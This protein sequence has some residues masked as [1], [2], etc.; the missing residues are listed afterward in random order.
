VRAFDLFTMAVA[1][2]V[3]VQ[4]AVIAALLVQRA[5][6]ARAARALRDDITQRKESEDALRDSQQRLTMA[7]AAGAVG[8]WDWNFATSELFID[9]G[10]KSLLGFG[11]A[12]ISTR[13]DDWGSR[14][15][16]D[17]AP[18]AAAQI[19]ACVDGH[20]DVYEIE[21]RM[22]HKDGSVR[23]FL[24]R[25]SA[26]R[27]A[28]GSLQR[29]VGTKVDITERKI[30]AEQFRLAIEAAPAGMLM[31]DRTDAIVLVNAQIE[32][33]FGY[34]R[35][36]LVTRSVDLLIPGLLGAGRELHG[37]RRDGARI[38]VEIRLNPID[39]RDGELVLV[40]VVDIAERQRA[41]REN[42]D[43]MQQLQHLAGSLITA[44]DAERARIARD[45][46]DDVS[47][48]LAGLSIALSG[49]KRR[50]A[51]LS[52]DQ[53]ASAAVS[54]IQQRAVSLAE[55]VRAL[56]HDL[57]PDVLKHAGL[58]AA[59]TA[60]CAALSRSQPIAVSCTA[61]GDFESIDG[62]TALCLYRITQEALHNVVKHAAARQAQVRLVRRSHIAE[63][64]IADDGK[65]FDVGETRK[66][67]KGLGL[68]SINER[69][70]LAGGTLSVMTESNK[71]TQVHVRLPTSA[72]PEAGKVPERFAAM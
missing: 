67:S 9:P 2:I 3:I 69:V 7:T 23:W 32:R 53:D 24:S 8:I 57:H 47:Q 71:G 54:A 41:E 21:H 49:L 19:Q 28:D 26:V 12:E 55:S 66:R 37:V 33:L 29:I 43:L 39:T 22:L 13:L 56:S 40:S 4:G 68:V 1:L 11:D 44:R 52:Q 20:S 60:H 50:V 58:T 48:Q 15:H 51:S 45:L 36:E 61:E 34:R 27:G 63:L 10:L 18:A 35:E 6:H 65:G 38:P 31:I 46:H 16:P 64:T 25:G 59:L 62:E 70:R 42:S 5:R 72:S 17:D 30:A 14:V